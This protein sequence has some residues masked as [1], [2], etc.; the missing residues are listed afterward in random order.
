MD[1]IFKYPITTAQRQEIIIPK[2]GNIISLFHDGRT[3]CLYVKFCAET[4]TEVESKM[5]R[6]YGTGN[7]I[8]DAEPLIFLG[9]IKEDWFIGHVFELLKP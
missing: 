5:I 9:T 8:P 6:V 3:W 4:Q 2:N 1:I 7:P